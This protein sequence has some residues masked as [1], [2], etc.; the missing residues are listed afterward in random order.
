M[1]ARVTDEIIQQIQK[2]SGQEYVDIY[3]KQAKDSLQP[4][5][6]EPD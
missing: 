4:P 1:V 5:A 2:L 3:A 6:A